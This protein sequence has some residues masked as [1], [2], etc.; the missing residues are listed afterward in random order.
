MYKFFLFKFIQI[1]Y[2]FIKINIIEIDHPDEP[3]QK[4]NPLYNEYKVVYEKKKLAFQ[5]YL[6]LFYQNNGTTGTRI[7]T[8]FEYRY[9]IFRI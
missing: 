6:K 5:T 2:K 9:K 1:Y 7:N 4:I 3:I 8:R